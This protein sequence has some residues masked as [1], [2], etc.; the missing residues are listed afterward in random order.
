MQLKTYRTQHRLTLADIVKRLRGVGMEVGNET[1]VH[2][3]EIGKRNVSVEMIE[4]YRKITN[5]AVTYAD[6]VDLKEIVRL[7]RAAA[8]RPL[9]PEMNS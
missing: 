2:R 6:W 8:E 9:Q 1:I 7:R 4:A 5:G 3:H